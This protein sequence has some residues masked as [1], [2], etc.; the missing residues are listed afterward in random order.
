MKKE[1]L[2]EKLR[3]SVES[4]RERLL[5]SKSTP[6]RIIESDQSNFSQWFRLFSFAVI[7]SVSSI[8]LVGGFYFL[9]I[10]SN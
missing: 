3:E 1:Q 4:V 2:K 7:L 10:L 5:P 6:M 8:P 9:H